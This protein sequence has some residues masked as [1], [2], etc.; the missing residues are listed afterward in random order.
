MNMSD[1]RHKEIL[2]SILF[3]IFELKNRRQEPLLAQNILS[4]GPV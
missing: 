3:Q 1:L 4:V 2:L